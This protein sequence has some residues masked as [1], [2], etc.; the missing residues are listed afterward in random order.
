MTR[1]ELEKRLYDMRLD[2]DC[3]GEL[4]ELETEIRGLNDA[5]LME[6][7]KKYEEA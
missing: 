5:E 3:I 2:M 4:D 6:L 7:I 1:E